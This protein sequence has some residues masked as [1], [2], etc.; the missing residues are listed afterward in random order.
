MRRGGPQSNTAILT[1][2]QLDAWQA[3]SRRCACVIASPR[4]KGSD[5]SIGGRV[6]RLRL[7]RG[8][9][10]R[11]R[12]S[13]GVSYAY[14]SRIESGQRIPSVR[15]IRV[16]ARRLGVTPEYL[17]SGVDIAP[18]EALEVRLTA[19]AVRLGVGAHRM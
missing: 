3:W 13:R 12:A 5:E 2:R 16:L 19:A 6:R 17:E 1:S 10:Q 18:G 9:S 11:K 14:I 7:G 8:R 15:A 4:T